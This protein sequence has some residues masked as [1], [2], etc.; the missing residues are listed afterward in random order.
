MTAALE[1]CMLGAPRGERAFHSN[2]LDG[3]DSARF[4]N[5]L[6]SASSGD[7]ESTEK[8]GA[9]LYDELRRLASVYLRDERAG[10]TLQ[11]TALV[12]EAYLRLAG[13]EAT[14]SAE[15]RQ[16][17]ALAAVQMRRVLVDYGR[18]RRTRKRGGRETHVPLDAARTKAAERLDQA[19]RVD[20]ALQSLA[21]LDPK[22]VQLVE[23]RYYAGFT[24]EETAAILGVS[25]S[26]I[27]RRWE[28]AKRWLLRE[29]SNETLVSD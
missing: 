17:F 16:F 6:G 8:V 26:T 15:T 14:P 11:P 9:L 2:E 23:L 13:Q 24:I 25:R 29:L 18:R 27:I 7:S 10:H 22:A 1:I 20:E 5:L 3:E 28:V 19:L 12:H 21:R 4:K